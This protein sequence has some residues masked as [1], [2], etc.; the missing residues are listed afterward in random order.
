MLGLASLLLTPGLGIAAPQP[1]KARGIAHLTTESLSVSSK[2]PVSVSLLND[3]ALPLAFSPPGVVPLDAKAPAINLDEVEVY[4]ASQTPPVV[5]PDATE[6]PV[7]GYLRIT[8]T[9]DATAAQTGQSELRI[10]VVTTPSRR[11]R[12]H[13]GRVY[14]VTLTKA[15]KDTTKTAT[16]ATEVDDL[17]MQRTFGLVWDGGKWPFAFENTWDGNELPVAI[18]GA[19]EDLTAT[20]LPDTYLGSDNA[21]T[22]QIVGTCTSS[23]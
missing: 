4:D 19:C 13:R 10:A 6:I 12:G 23:T 20:Q 17:T 16:V 21:D 14:S 18:T 2:E 5:I 22:V 1:A 15:T 9:S 11:D 7:G 3:T 8:V